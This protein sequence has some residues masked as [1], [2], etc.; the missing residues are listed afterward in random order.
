M[1]A[2]RDG[3]LSLEQ[4]R[5]CGLAGH[6]IGVRVRNG[7]LHRIHRGVYAVGHPGISLRGRF[8]AAV[9]ACGRGT[10]LA[11]HAAA[12]EWQFISWRERPIE[13][14]VTR[15][16]ARRIEGVHARRS[17]SLTRRDV[18][19]RDGIPVT[20]PARTLLDLATVLPERALRRA[21]RQAQALRLV[22]TDE[23]LEIADRCN[24]HHG[25]A[26][27]RAGVADGPAATR[28]PLED[29]LLDLVEGAGLRRPDVNVPLRVG[30]ET[31]IPDLL[32]RDERVAVEADSVT[33]HDNKLTREHDAHKQ[34]ILEAAGWRVVRVTH[35]QAKRHPGQTLARIRAAL[36]R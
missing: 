9:L 24:G 34:A 2:A 6:A 14:L 32:W 22:S 35:D 1:A 12:A 21:A 36:S 15:G 25:A 23:L 33:W 10:A 17:R 16:G 28:S 13:V 27:L 30:G 3:V 19:L 7:S 4:L 18:R 26:N 20:S 5:A 31:I 11:F 8:R 29:M